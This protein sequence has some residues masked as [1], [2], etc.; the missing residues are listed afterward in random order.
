[1][2]LYLAEVRVCPAAGWGQ[3]R[4]AG[5]CTGP[6]CRAEPERWR[7]LMSS[8]LQREQESAQKHSQ[9]HSHTQSLSSEITSSHH[10]LENHTDPTGC[11]PRS[12]SPMTKCCSSQWKSHNTVF[13]IIKHRVLGTPLSE[14]ERTI[15]NLIQAIKDYTKCT[16]WMVLRMHSRLW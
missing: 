5:L 13:L 12:Y 14:A 11:H 9:T 8:Q 1:M 2:N 6:G 3:W 15:N 4:R 10:A 16:V 7:G